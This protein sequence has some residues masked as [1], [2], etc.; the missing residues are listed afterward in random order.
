MNSFSKLIICIIAIA[1]A[2]IPTA[3]AQNTQQYDFSSVSINGLDTYKIYTREQITDALG[4]P[5]EE[6]NVIYKYFVY[7]TT[8]VMA[9]PSG[10]YS[11]SDAKA[12]R[13]VVDELGYSDVGKDSIKICVFTLY[14]DRF[15]VNDYVRVGD[16]VSK[17]YDMGGK[18]L[19]EE[20]CSRIYWAPEGSP[21]E[22]W[23]E[24]GCYPRFY[25]DDNGI[26]T[27]IELYH[28]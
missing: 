2:G 15:A 21:D 6:D 13:N 23:I 16:P 17:V 26:I 20:D 11:L 14:S 5:D 24:W 28:D 22:P 25:Y 19:E 7:H 10:D 4:E 12:V 8:M 18:T 1:S 3:A 27:D 9:P